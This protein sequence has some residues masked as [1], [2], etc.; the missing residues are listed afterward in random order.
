[1]TWVSKKGGNVGEKRV[2]DVGGVGG[3][4]IKKKK[5]R[6]MGVGVKAGI[7][8]VG[9]KAGV[10]DVGVKMGVTSGSRWVSRSGGGVEW[11]EMGWSDVRL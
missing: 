6:D 3:V 5:F 1:M 10:G 2:G 7:G 4:G 9:V 11:R 8:V